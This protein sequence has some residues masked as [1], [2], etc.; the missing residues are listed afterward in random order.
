V[1]DDGAWPSNR[2][3]LGSGWT[4]LLFTDGIF[5]GRTGRG[6]E[7]LGADGLMAMFARL[8]PKA[9]K[10]G[11]VADQLVREVEAANGEAL[12]DDVALFL[13]SNAPHWS[14]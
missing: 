10:L 1:I 7:R 13:L 6:S 8:M 12:R 5:E 14:E 2:V 9:S 4:L 3:D 11:L